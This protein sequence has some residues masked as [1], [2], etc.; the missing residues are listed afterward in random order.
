MYHQKSSNA[1]VVTFSIPEKKLWL[2]IIILAPNFFPL[3]TNT[4]KSFLLEVG[5]NNFHIHTFRLAV[6]K[7]TKAKIIVK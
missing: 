2:S 3:L 6:D 4:V 5:K 1:F 7:N